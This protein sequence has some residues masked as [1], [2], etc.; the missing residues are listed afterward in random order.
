MQRKYAGAGI[1]RP[2]IRRGM[3]ETTTSSANPRAYSQS[4]QR[5]AIKEGLEQKLS[6]CPPR[7]LKE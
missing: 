1:N 6:L 2:K 7:S 3:Y 4:Y 5:E